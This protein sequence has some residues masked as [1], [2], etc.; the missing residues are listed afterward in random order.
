M[1]CIPQVFNFLAGGAGANIGRNPHSSA[2]LKPK[3]WS[4]LLSSYY[5]MINFGFRPSLALKSRR[6]S[7]IFHEE[8]LEIGS[9]IGHQTHR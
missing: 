5:P 4:V 3:N 7:K 8:E 2:A 6:H 1:V 9:V